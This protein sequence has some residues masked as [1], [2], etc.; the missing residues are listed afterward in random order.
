M[1]R[2]HRIPRRSELVVVYYGS[3]AHY[4]RRNRS[5]PRRPDCNPTLRPGVLTRY[6]TAEK[7]GK[8]PC[9]DCWGEDADWKTP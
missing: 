4:H 8:T 5:D 7:E 6:Q 2:R 3:D 1:S 9:A